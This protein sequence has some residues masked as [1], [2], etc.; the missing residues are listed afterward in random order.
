MDSI[1]PY[2]QPSVASP[3][4]NSLSGE[5][6][7]AADGQVAVSVVI[8]AHDE[9]DNIAACIASVG[10]AAEVIVVENDS[11]DDTVSIARES[12]AVVISPPF[13]T[14]GAARN[15]GIGQ[16]SHPWILILD[17]DER[18]TPEL[19]SELR[20]IAAR[21]SFSAYRIPRR[22]FFLGRE[23]KHGGWE[24]DRPVRFFGSGCRYDEKKVH[25]SVRTGD[26]AVRETRHAM[27]HYTYRSLD[28]YFAK[29][30]RYSRDWADQNFAKG[31][32]ADAVMPIIRSR[33]R[34]VSM[35]FLRAGFLDGTHG[36]ILARLA[37]LSVMAKYARLWELSLRE[38]RPSPE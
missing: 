1:A 35:Y 32:R 26:N 15:A 37:E 16:A 20:D 30:D 38:S 19:A 21:E 11:G 27:L 34:F 23:I 8:A 9:A 18:C 36:L 25:E 13:T 17:A 5:S 29:L 31:R 2:R 28:Q 3:A 4:E 24:R 33:L 12:G 14:I 22:N 10:W 6:R 7:L